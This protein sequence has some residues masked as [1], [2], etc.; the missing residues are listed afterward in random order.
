MVIGSDILP[1]ILKKGVRHNVAGNLIAQE[2]VFGWYISA[3]KAEEHISLFTT[4]VC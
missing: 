3:P 2:T 1:F 4:E